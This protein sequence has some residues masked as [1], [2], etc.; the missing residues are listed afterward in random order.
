MDTSTPATCPFHAPQTLKEQD[1]PV[2]V[3]SNR[4]LK[5]LPGPDGLPILGNILQ[6][7]LTKLHSILEQW[8]DTYGPLYKFRIARKNVVAVS[9]PNLINEVL[10]KRPAAYRR[11]ESIAPV[12]TEMGINGVFSAEGEQWLR[13]RR[14]AMQA[15]NTAHLKTFFPTLMKVTERLKKRWDQAMAEGA[16]IDVQ[17]DLMRY[18]IDVTSNLAFGYDVNTLEDQGAEIQRHLEKV[19][20]MVNRRINAPFPYWHFVKLPADRALDHALV[21]IRAALT[22]CIEQ[23]RKR[24]AKNPDLATHPTNFLE[25]MLAARDV[26]G[27]EIT[28][29]EIFGNVL[30]MLIGGEDSTA[31]T[32]AW[33]LHFLTDH[34]DSQ[35][36]V[37][38]E[39]DDVLGPSEILRDFRDAERLT[40]LEAVSFETLRLKSVFPILFL[41]ANTDV[42]LGGVNIP[43][44]TAIFLL[45]RQCGMQEHEFTAAD[46]FQP[47]RW[48]TP[49]GGQEQGHNPKAFVPFGA[50]PRSC[51]GRNLTLLEIKSAM[52]MLFRNFS[53]TKSTFTKPVDEH[54]GF[55]MAPKNLSVTFQRRLR[56]DGHDIEQTDALDE[57]SV[58]SVGV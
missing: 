13:Q 38:K 35:R 30:T 37:Q 29:E 25:A 10:R 23:S 31:A 56:I 47:E 42:E 21:A 45:T 2:S 5:N 14:T 48:T 28:E 33:M 34:P 11:L 43:K 4:T 19:F 55:L 54:F 17:E 39:L 49:H 46:Q 22:E 52:A 50:G 41:G 1:G 12:L 20:P 7:D 9:D 53:I 44:G 16:S 36:R 51:P 57:C 26:D 27:A 15:L 24:L 58:T 18:T 32:M 3:H 6:L 40:Y 8:A